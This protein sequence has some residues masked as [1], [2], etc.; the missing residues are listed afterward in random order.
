MK[1]IRPFYAFFVFSTQIT[2]VFLLI[3]YLFCN[4][5]RIASAQVQGART[6]AFVYTGGNGYSGSTAPVS[7]YAINPTSG[8]LSLVNGSPFALPGRL[9]AIRRASLFTWPRMTVLCR[10]SRL[11]ARRVR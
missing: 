10:P 11:T 2:F 5:S 8:T 3:F 6:G 4:S 7:G 1:K 9:L